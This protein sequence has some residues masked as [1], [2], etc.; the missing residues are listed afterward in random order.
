MTTEHPQGSLL[1]E[2]PRQQR[3]RLPSYTAGLFEP[4]TRSKTERVLD[5]EGCLANIIITNAAGT[6]HISLTAIH[7]KHGKAWG[8]ERGYLREGR[9]RKLEK[10]IRFTHKSDA[11]ACLESMAKS[12]ESE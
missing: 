9:T 12:L 5:D 4:K 1:A 6:T 10:A 2:L 3:A 8:V 11:V 7:D